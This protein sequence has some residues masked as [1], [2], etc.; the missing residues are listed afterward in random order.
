MVA[1][2]DPESDA[3]ACDFLELHDR[4]RRAGRNRSLPEYQQLFPGHEARIALELASLGKAPP[5]DRGTAAAVAVVRRIGRYRLLQELGHGGQ[6]VVW[7]AH[8]E[9]LD[10][11]VALKLLDAGG[12]WLSQAR[13]DR[14]QREANA[15]ARLDHPNICTIYEAEL[16][17][18][19]PFLAMRYIVGETLAQRLLRARERPDASSERLLGALPD[20]A[21]RIAQVLELG[22]KLARALHSAHES[23][24]VHRD[25][26][27][28]NV[29][30]TEDDEP[31]I[32]DFG[33]ARTEDGDA[34]TR[35]RA[36]ELFGSLAYLPPERF[37]GSEAD[38]RGDVY[39]L[40]VTLYEC[41]TLARPYAAQTTTELLAEVA[42][43]RR[44]D[45][46]RHN[47]AI[48]RDLALV[49][50]T[51]LEPDPARR[52]AKALDLAEDLRRLRHHQPIV[53]RPIGT[54]LRAR[55]WLRRH[56]V[57]AVAA[58][59]VL[60][61][62]LV[63]AT[64]L[65]QLTAQRRG[66]LAWQQVLEAVSSTDQPTEALGR[67][68][69]AAPHVPAAKLDGPLIELLTRSTARLELTAERLG[70]PA[71]GAPFFTADDRHLLVPTVD[72]ALVAVDSQTG[73]CTPRASL[74]PGA[75]TYLRLAGNGSRAI[76]SGHD[77]RVRCFDPATWAELPLPAAIA[78]SNDDVDQV[79]DP[80]NRLPRL[81][82][83]SRDGGRLA[84][85]GFDGSLL[86]AATSEGGAHWR[87]D[88][89]G[90]WTQ[91]A[92]FAPDGARLVVHWRTDA[93]RQAAAR[94]SVYATDGGRELLELAT[95]GQETISSNFDESGGR[96]AVSGDDGKI[97]V[98]DTAT[99]QCTHELQALGEE[100]AHVYWVGFAP[101]ADQ[102]VTLGF[103]GLTVWDL[104]TRQRHKQ[105]QAASARP[106]HT[107]AFCEDGT[108]LAAVVKDGTVRVYDT[109]TWSQIS[110][111]RWSQ[112][113]PDEIVWNHRGDRF[114]FQDRR[115]LQVVTLQ[116]PAPELRPHGD[117]IL[118]LEFLA[119]GRRVLTASRDAT[120]SIVD[121]DSGRAERVLRHPAAVTSARLSTD[122]TRIVT[123]CGDGTV[124]VW[125][126][127][128]GSAP[129]LQRHAHTGA[130]ID[131]QFL[132]ANQRVLSIGAEGG[133]HLFAADTGIE[134]A[135]MRAH[136]RACL[137]AAVDEELGL[138]ATGGAD[139]RVLVHDLE[140]RFVIALAT[141]PPDAAPGF[142]IQGNATALAFDRARRRLVVANRRDA[143]VVFALDG[144][145]P[146]WVEA[147]TQGQQYSRHLAMAPGSRFYATAH[148]GVGDWT[149]V[150]AATLV[151]DDVGSGNFPSAIVSVLRYSPDGRLL[152]VASRD[153]SVSL[154]DL[155]RRQ[156]GLDLRGQ[157]GGIRSAVFSQNGDW[158]ATGSQD[159]TLRAWP[160]QPLPFAQRHYE[161]LT[162]KRAG[163]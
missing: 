120:A 57:F 47:R 55:R 90:W 15:L 108:R 103:E 68:L 3:A 151:P 45:P 20:R 60:T 124:R 148:S 50:E 85:L 106:F 109:A 160:V 152:L 74:H 22:E 161:R 10:R 33:V 122:E 130:V 42:A 44:R 82:L 7:L 123:A 158:V 125:A 100:L 21:S 70:A 117:A 32:L 62:L 99:W 137:C 105:L 34:L 150:D 118:S 14:L 24:V 76:S 128:D 94:V 140:G 39:A 155:E 26:K 58:C 4:D 43:G 52:Y 142:A 30:L 134:V 56:P 157:H 79:A 48:A 153:D 51:T 139:H 78:H 46:T 163:P 146:H 49:L 116:A 8:D 64:L 2:D 98:F 87:V 6:A 138:I 156:R 17:G 54:L 113:Y 53:A 31:V 71:S 84:L 65:A 77:G 69:A 149:F 11:R 80:L 133:V 91:F 9:M 1:H 67:V 36:G 115:G 63:A 83:L 111:A 93:T 96:Y 12:G 19:T 38:R 25:V 72:G 102:L 143:M 89:R 35:T 129:R 86:V 75:L 23:G 154:W 13:R 121:L 144:W 92:R 159:G 97:R 27:P 132:A 5:P 107:A 135:T 59:L 61:A 114:A 147:R 119:D 110:T 145:R 141:L 127:D 18:E 95:G 136:E 28:Q 112:R 73:A 104:N 37:H 126:R 41:L 29:M 131:A 40:G 101:R 88:H 16:G 162:G 81:P 66:L